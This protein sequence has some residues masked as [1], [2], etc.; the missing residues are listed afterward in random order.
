MSDAERIL[1]KID[2]AE[3]ICIDLATGRTSSY[4]EYEKSRAE[5]LCEPLLKAVI[6]DWLSS[7]RNESRFWGKMKQ[8]SSTYQGRREFLWAEFDG[9]RS[10]LERSGVENTSHSVEGTVVHH[11]ST[12]VNEAW[13]RCMQRLNEDP[14]AAITA[15]R[16]MVESVCIHVLESKGE[17]HNKKDDLVALYRRTAKLLNLSPE[18]HAEQLFKKILG[19]C[20]SVVEGLAS[21]RNA[22]G[23]AHGKGSR[24]FRPSKRHA[25]LAVNLAGTISTFLIATLEKE[26]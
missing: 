2:D 6:P 17:C 16:S 26:V 4:E 13:T 7:C 18:Q 8:I 25:V 11:T 12:G 19:G 3:H 24:Y 5:L 22:F 15:A 14:E 1:R 9:L 10:A 23:D 20:S 21:L